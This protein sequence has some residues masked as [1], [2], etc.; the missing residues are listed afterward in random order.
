MLTI[1]KNTNKANKYTKKKGRKI[2]S[3][4]K[5]LYNFYKLILKKHTTEL[6]Y[7]LFKINNDMIIM[8]EGHSWVVNVIKINKPAHFP[9]VPV[10]GEINFDLLL[11][12]F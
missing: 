8:D 9:G 7:S 11:V 2:N 10:E 4:S 1:K 6:K 5:I 3:D 12:K